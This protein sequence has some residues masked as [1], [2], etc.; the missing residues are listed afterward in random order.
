MVKN[1]I[2]PEGKT[3][4]EVLDIIEEVV[5]S[6][7]PKFVFGHYDLDDIKQE[8]YKQA[9]EALSR[10]DPSRPLQN[11]LF[12]HLKNR[13]RNLKRNKFRRNDNPC[14]ACHEQNYCTGKPEPCKKYSKWLQRNNSKSNIAQPLSI[15]YISD[16]KEKN[17]RLESSVEDDVSIKEI[18]EKIDEALPVS[19]RSTYLKMRDGLSVP[20]NK[21]KKIEEIVLKI[22][23]EHE[24]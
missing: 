6:L 21:K 16:E 23:Q 2:I 14:K 11:F 1:L 4:K 3:E 8:G 18:M 5:S 10:Y 24:N 19:L 20:M 13:F 17:T 12:V 22:I 9:I 15:N 7:A